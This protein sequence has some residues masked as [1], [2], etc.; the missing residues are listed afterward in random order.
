MEVMDEPDEGAGDH[1]ARLILADA[2]YCRVTKT[3]K[4]SSY[5]C[6]WEFPHRAQQAYDAFDDLARRLDECVGRHAV[7][8]R[9]QSVNHPD[10]YALRRYETP[11]AEVSVSVKDKSAL[12]QTFVFLRIQGGQGH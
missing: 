2:S 12:G 10:S 6:G 7:L 1:N 11:A 8:H 5:H 9:D 4:R 3:S